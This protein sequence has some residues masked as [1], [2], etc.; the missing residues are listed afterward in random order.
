MN[1]VKWMKKTLKS[2]VSIKWNEREHLNRHQIT[3]G[4]C[5]FVSSVS[6]LLLLL[7]FLVSVWRFFFTLIASFGQHNINLGSVCVHVQTYNLHSE[8]EKSYEIIA[9]A[10][11]NLCKCDLPA[12]TLLVFGAICVKRTIR[13]IFFRCS[14]SL[15][16]IRSIFVLHIFKNYVAL[17]SFTYF[18][19]F[20]SS[21]K[22]LVDMF[23]NRPQ[24]KYANEFQWRKQFIQ[25]SKWNENRR[26]K[27]RQVPWSNENN[28]NTSK[29]T[30]IK[31]RLCWTLT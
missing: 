21:T 12:V 28:D 14:F 11:V 31:K 15:S 10:A 25:L 17:F 29:Q 22:D 5:V 8:A 20:A 23:T 13:Q 18:F 26:M 7:F 24:L 16:C 19:C 4:R 30:I 3:L 6:L 27:R 9:I 2:D 1:V